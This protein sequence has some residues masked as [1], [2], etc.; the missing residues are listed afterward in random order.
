MIE[1]DD[2]P[3]PEQISL[4]EPLNESYGAICAMLTEHMVDADRLNRWLIGLMLVALHDAD[5]S[6]VPLVDALE[7]VSDMNYADM[8]IAGFDSMN[9]L[10]GLIKKERQRGRRQK[11]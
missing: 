2:L 6:D 8:A 4:G 5:A 11:G 7:V 1:S 3:D 9:T 10:V